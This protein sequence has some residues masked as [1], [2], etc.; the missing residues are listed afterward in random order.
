MRWR[1]AKCREAEEREA[2]ER[3]R[4]ARQDPREEQSDLAGAPPVSVLQDP[5]PL[6][7]HGRVPAA[8]CAM[9]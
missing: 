1:R 7:S 3:D 6:P 4:R 5:A 2:A 8:I 9:G